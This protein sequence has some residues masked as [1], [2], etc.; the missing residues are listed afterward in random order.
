MEASPGQEFHLGNIFLCFFPRVFCV[1]SL[2]L[3]LPE[4]P[5]S[6]ILADAFWGSGVGGEDLLCLH[7]FVLIA[8]F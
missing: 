6:Y 3:S 4:L 7:T 8:D 1:F 5:P 2:L